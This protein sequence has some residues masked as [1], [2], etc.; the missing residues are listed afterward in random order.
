[1]YIN[2]TGLEGVY[3][4]YLTWLKFWTLSVIQPSKNSQRFVGWKHFLL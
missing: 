2:K 1:M 4:F 3:L